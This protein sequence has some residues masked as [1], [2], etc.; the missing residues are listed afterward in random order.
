[1]QVDSAV[2]TPPAV[3][4]T[5]SVVAKPRGQLLVGIG[6]GAGGTAWRGDPLGAASLS[7]G[8]RLY[9]AIALIAQGRLGYGRVDQRQLAAILVGLAGGGYLT[10]RSYGRLSVAF[11]HQHEESL[12]AVAEQPAGALLGIGTGIRHRAGVQVGIGWD[13][14]AYRQPKYEITVGPEVTIS[15]LTY[16]TGPSIYGF[17]GIAAGGS[18]R[19]F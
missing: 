10:E 4:A 16:S 17:G 15:Y 6:L 19:L 7:I 14:V 9:R 2:E 11:I 18:F 8:F 3:I 1:M 5:E 12:A 13:F